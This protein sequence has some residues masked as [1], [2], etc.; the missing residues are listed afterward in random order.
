MHWTIFAA[1]APVAASFWTAND[2]FVGK[3][4]VDVS[5]STIVDEMRVEALPGNMYRFSFEGAPSETVVADGT[6]QPGLPGTTLSVRTGPGRTLAV[7]R[8]QDGRIIVSANWKLSQDGS[9]LS[10]AFTSF[11]PDGSTTTVKYLYRRVSG[12][13]GFA[14]A[15]ES[16]TKPIGLKLELAIKPYE[17]AGL[18]FVSGGS[19][20]NVT[21]DGREHVVPGAK[22]SLSFSGRRNGARAMEY[23][24]KISGKVERVR[25]FEISQDG[26]ILTET[27]RTQG[28]KIPAIFVFD[29]E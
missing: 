5:R 1:I 18:T 12:T 22:N 28:Q 4:M 17:R 16:T 6:D 8:K 25:Q 11:Q 20:K 7:L 27:L 23:R 14:G 21:F 3:W 9:T 10:D 15:W 29:R 2:P 13:S 26:R 24:E 19:D